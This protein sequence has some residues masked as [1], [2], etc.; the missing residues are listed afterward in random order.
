MRFA[1]Y[2][3]R[4]ASKFTQA[5]L[6]ELTGIST[7]VVNRLFTG[8]Q[9]PSFEHL[10]RL[11]VVLGL[12]PALLFDAAGMDEGAEICRSWMPE[13]ESLA[14]QLCRRVQKLVRHGDSDRVDAALANIELLWDLNRDAFEELARKTDCEAAC[15]VGD[16]QVEG[17]VLYCWRCSEEEA[18]QLA[19]ERK[20]PGWR[21][22]SG[23]DE[24][25][26]LD[27]FLRKGKANRNEVQSTLGYWAAVFRSALS[28]RPRSL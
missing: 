9:K 12:H 26:A 2:L 5:Q 24:A 10:M 8:D 23:S 25:V 16:V 1:N 4:A 17:D 6:A 19:R 13:E 21:R 14:R 7:S 28:R 3:R 20:A 27:L 22:F 15:L 11:S 18:Q